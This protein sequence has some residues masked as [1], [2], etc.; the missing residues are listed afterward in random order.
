MA[1]K[2]SNLYSKLNLTNLNY[3][4]KKRSCFRNIWQSVT[5]N[6]FWNLHDL[7]YDEIN[8]WLTTSGERLVFDAER[9]TRKENSWKAW[10]VVRVKMKKWKERTGARVCSIQAWRAGLNEEN[11][12]H[13][14]CGSQVQPT[15]SVRHRVSST[16]R[17]L[18]L[19]RSSGVRV[20]T[21]Q[22]ILWPRP[23]LVDLQNVRYVLQTPLPVK[24]D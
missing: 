12:E 20:H 7:K 22:A 23:S 3:P 15:E 16:H 18:C 10:V 9:D 4:S 21:G 14:R 2:K 1:C 19:T 5:I 17:V 6:V 13:F 8:C 11:E 24:F